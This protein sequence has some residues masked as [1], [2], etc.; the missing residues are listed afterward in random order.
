MN[1]DNYLSINVSVSK[2]RSLK[3]LI[4]PKQLKRQSEFASYLNKGEHYF[5][6]CFFSFLL[7]HAACELVGSILFRQT[8]I[9]PTASAVEKQNLRHWTTREGLGKYYCD[10]E[11]VVSWRG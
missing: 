4:S 1:T 11:L 2:A 9:K 5:A 7:C 10:Y 6:F 8:G 3:I